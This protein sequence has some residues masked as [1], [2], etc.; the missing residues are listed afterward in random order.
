LIRSSEVQSVEVISEQ[1]GLSLQVRS[2]NTR[3]WDVWSDEQRCE[4]RSGTVK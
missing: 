2:F 4:E 3:S 1:V